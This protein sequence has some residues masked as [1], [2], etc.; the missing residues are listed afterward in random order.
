[1]PGPD[2]SPSLPPTGFR[3]SLPNLLTIAR[4]I[5]AAAFFGVLTPWRYAVS[6]AARGQGIDTWLLLAAFL[7]ILAAATDALDGYLARRW[8]V[9]SVFGRVM[10]PFADK[11]L[12]IGG[13]VFLAGPG[14]WMARE[15]GGTA[16]VS[17]V[18]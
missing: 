10:D 11:L 9:V 8:R 13:F 1:M 17:R 3:R 14:F 16:V 15:G 2:P 18:T 7:F 5:I 4:V 12:V 6:S